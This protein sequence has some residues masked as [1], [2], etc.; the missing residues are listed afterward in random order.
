M[1]TIYYVYFIMVSEFRITAGL[2]ASL[3]LDF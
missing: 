1:K 3:F 2:P